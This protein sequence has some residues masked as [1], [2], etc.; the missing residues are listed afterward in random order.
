MST[1]GPLLAFLAL[2]WALAID[3]A[4][5][6]L[7]VRSLRRQC[8]EDYGGG[9]GGG[10][11]G[12]GGDDGAPCDF[13]R[14]QEL[15]NGMFML[16]LGLAFTLAWACTTGGCPAVPQLQLQPTLQRTLMHPGTRLLHEPGLAETRMRTGARADARTDDDCAIC[17]EP[18]E[19]D[20]V[21]NVIAV[22]KCGHAFHRG[23]IAAW[24]N[25]RKSCPLCCAPLVIIR[26]R[27]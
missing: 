24:L 13:R 5:V 26:V 25:V 23:C 17:L 10:D 9:D 12:D 3:G 22:D 15:G 18:L 7:V 20:P 4:G 8:D 21:D 19:L 2:A 16:A 1:V 27:M 14:S 6:F 11:G